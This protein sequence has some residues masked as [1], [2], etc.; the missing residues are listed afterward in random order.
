MIAEYKRHMAKPD[1]PMVHYQCAFCGQHGSRRAS[2]IKR[3]GLIF[4]DTRCQML[5]RWRRAKTES[6][7]VSARDIFALR[8]DHAEII[9]KITGAFCSRFCAHGLREDVEREVLY[10]ITHLL[11]FRKREDVTRRLLARSV[12]MGLV[13]FYFRFILPRGRGEY[14]AIVSL[15]AIVERGGDV[16]ATKE[17][18]SA[19]SELDGLL[20]RKSARCFAILRDVA[21]G[22]SHRELAEKYNVSTRDVTSSVHYATRALA[23]LERTLL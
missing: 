9:R 18:V 19:M 11:R 16:P 15:D 5:H 7:P 8:D 6:L 14:G 4:C 22:M 20:A 21:H 17:R 12:K 3:T 2:K 13:G 1:T 10:I 23:K